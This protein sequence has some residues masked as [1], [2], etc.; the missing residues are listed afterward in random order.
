[1]QSSHA[2]ERCTEAERCQQ[3]ETDEPGTGRV[4]QNWNE[5]KEEKYRSRPV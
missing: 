1:M 2:H 3:A 4:Q 5:R